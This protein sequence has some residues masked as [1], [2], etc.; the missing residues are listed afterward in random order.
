M[1]PCSAITLTEI[2]QHVSANSYSNFHAGLFVADG[3]SRGFTDGASP[4]VP[5]YQH[6]LARDFIHSNFTAMGYDTWLDPFSFNKTFSS[7]P[8]N[9]TYQGCNNVVAVKWG[10]GGTNVYIV[11]AHYDS[12]DSGQP[13][14]TGICPGADDNAS[15]VSGMLEAARVIQEHVFRDTIIFIAFDGE[16][17]DFKGSD[18]FVGTHTTTSILATNETVFLRS[19]IKGM[20]SADMIGYDDTNTVMDIVIGRVN[21]DDSPTADAVEQA[22]T[23]YTALAP[24]QGLGWTGS[25]HMPFHNVGIP[26]I[27]FI[28]GDYYDYWNNPPEYEN[29]YYHSDGD[30]IDS[31]NYI[32]YSYAS[33]ATKCIVGYLCEQAQVIPPATLVQSVTGG[34]TLELCWFTAPNVVYNLYGADSLLQTNPWTFIQ[35]F[36]P[37]NATVE[38][39][40]QLDLNTVTQSMF[41]V[42]SQ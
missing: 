37:T 39:S 36:P 35:S 14:I 42:E 25:D 29:P 40:I 27:L 1:A 23:N 2:T 7:N 41:R 19:S 17:K 3:N 38:F 15:G 6:D 18:H 33:E 8:T 34:S 26:S 32:S 22:L 12:V 9:Y 31:P 11:G 10:N 5:A 20:I 13:N 21:T 4:R 16:E 30:S 28:E 24:Y